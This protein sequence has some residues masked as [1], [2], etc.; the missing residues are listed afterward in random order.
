[1]R[2]DIRTERNEW[3]TDSLHAEYT[4]TQHTHIQ[5]TH[6]QFTYKITHLIHTLIY[7]YNVQIK[8]I[9]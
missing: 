8:R 9:N 2:R 1:M 7:S 5:H 6:T 4:H 3:Y